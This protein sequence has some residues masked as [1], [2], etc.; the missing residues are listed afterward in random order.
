M[1]RR[2]N[3]SG[4]LGVALLPVQKELISR[5]YLSIPFHMNKYLSRQTR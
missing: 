2:K 5:V 1:K 4:F 3:L